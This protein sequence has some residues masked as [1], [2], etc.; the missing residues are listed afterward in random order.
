MNENQSLINIAQE[1]EGKSDIFIVWNTSHWP[2]Y[3]NMEN[4]NKACCHYQF[5]P[6]EKYG[7]WVKR[8]WIY[9]NE[10]ETRLMYIV[11]INQQRGQVPENPNCPACYSGSKNYNLAK[12]GEREFE[13]SYI[14]K[15]KC[16]SAYQLKLLYKFDQIVKLENYHHWKTHKSLNPS[17]L[18]GG[19]V[20]VSAYEDLLADIFAKR[21]W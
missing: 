20:P 1:V 7:L 17:V 18:R 15:A 8:L 3:K 9:V 12:Q 5:E 6:A 13:A 11:E 2:H 21:I 10:P 19:N 14:G 16:D 4:I